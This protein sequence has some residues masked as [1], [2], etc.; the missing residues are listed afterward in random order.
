MAI[1]TIGNALVLDLKVFVGPWTRVREDINA[2]DDDALGSV[3][4]PETQQ[5]GEE[6]TLCLAY[7][8][9]HNKGFQPILGRFQ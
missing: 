5:R 7:M 3:V 2:S 8:E 6:D 9:K 1:L 4:A